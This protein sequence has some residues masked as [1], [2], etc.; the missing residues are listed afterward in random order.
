MNL[1]KNPRALGKWFIVG[2]V[3]L[4]F[5]AALVYFSRDISA[6]SASMPDVSFL[7]KNMRVEKIFMSDEYSDEQI[8]NALKNPTYEA[9]G[10][11]LNSKI[12]LEILS[13]SKD[14]SARLNQPAKR[15]FSDRAKP[16]S[17]KG[18]FIDYVIWT[19][20]SKGDILVPSKESLTIDSPKTDSDNFVFSP[21]IFNARKIFF[22][23]VYNKIE[24]I[25]GPR[26]SDRKITVQVGTGC[27][28]HFEASPNTIVLCNDD[29]NQDWVVV[30]ELAHAFHGLYCLNGI[31]E[32]GFAVSV[33]DIVVP[34]D[35]ANERGFRNDIYNL[36][37]R[38]YTERYGVGS[39]RYISTYYFGSS[40]M[41]K[42]YI[43]NKSF[44]K[45]FNTDIYNS[46]LYGFQFTDGI[47]INLIAKAVPKVENRDTKIW[48]VDQFAFIPSAVPSGDI[49]LEIS[50]TQSSAL[51][52]FDCYVD[53]SVVKNYT[54]KVFGTDGGLLGTTTKRTEYSEFYI[55]FVDF[56][57]FIGPAKLNAYYKST[58]IVKFEYFTNGDESNKRVQYLPKVAISE[59]ESEEE[60]YGNIFGVVI[61]D[62]SEVILRNL[63]TGWKKSYTISNGAFRVDD[64]EAIAE[65]KYQ[66]TVIKKMP[67]G[68]KKVVAY[69]YFNK[70]N[71]SGYK[72][73]AS[74]LPSDYDLQISKATRAG[75]ILNVSTKPSVNLSQ[76][77][78]I[79]AVPRQRVWGSASSLSLD[80]SSY[81]GK[82]I[83]LDVFYN[84]GLGLTKKRT[85]SIR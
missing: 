22:E 60:I 27:T 25:V 71:M 83:Q 64:S 69:K 19:A 31:W 5:I 52:L 75:S 48:F 23:E 13:K 26:L 84:D 34:S 44:F 17:D 68:S 61:G 79:G 20:N 3:L 41:R 38:A 45:Q 24:E 10:D 14:L 58:G 43:E 36:P 15:S 47:L 33:T 81:V 67:A 55:D 2:V 28:S 35:Q 82:T 66:M 49:H 65:G 85:R 4:V 46:S 18:K 11:D 78:S 50:D 32:E 7:N 40:L 8:V 51:D 62:A 70:M 72:V 56:W 42:L 16:L 59:G 80:A 77:F 9:K 21:Y 12:S 74:V 29:I 63:D 39:G 37:F 57:N 6:N 1:M 53:G 54:I 30:H 76:Y 73:V